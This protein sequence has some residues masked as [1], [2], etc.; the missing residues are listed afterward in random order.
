M[1]KNIKDKEVE[2]KIIIILDS[3]I[4]RSISQITEELYEKYKIKISPQITKRYL[5]KLED[6]GKYK[7]ERKN[8]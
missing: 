2:E 5:L 7:I 3:G 8:G 4:F 1:E 6:E